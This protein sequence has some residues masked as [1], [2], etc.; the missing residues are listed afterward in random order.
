MR[1]VPQIADPNGQGCARCWIHLATSHLHAPSQP[2]Q[3]SIRHPALLSNSKVFNPRILPPQS[4]PAGEASSTPSQAYFAADSRRL[5]P[6][7]NQIDCSL[8]TFVNC[9]SSI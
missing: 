9:L 5:N 6:F 7:T 4:L 8:P 3:G 1:L 2:R